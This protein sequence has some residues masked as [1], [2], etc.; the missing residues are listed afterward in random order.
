MNFIYSNDYLTLDHSRK[1]D[2]TDIYDLYLNLLTIEIFVSFSKII[3]HSNSIIPS[4][5][6]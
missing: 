2:S 4:N 1:K 3:F 6:K 5:S